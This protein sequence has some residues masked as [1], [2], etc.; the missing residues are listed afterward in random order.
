MRR[1]RGEDRR[2][3]LRAESSSP[4]ARG[5]RGASTPAR[6]AAVAAVLVA[7]VVVVVLLFGGN[8]GY[9]YTLMFQTGGQIVPGN[10]VLVAGQRVGMVDSIDLTDDNEAA[11]A[12]EHAGAAPRGHHGADPHDLALGRRQPLHLARPR[13]PTT[14]PRSSPVRRSRARTPP[15]R[16]TSTSSSTSSGPSSAQPCRSSSRATRPSTR[17]RA[18]SPTAPTSSSTPPSA[19]RPSS[20]PSSRSDSAALSRFLV[21]GSQTFGALADR[22]QDLSSLIVT[23]NHDPGRD[24]KPQRGPR[25]LARRLPRDAAPA[26]HDAGEPAKPPSTT[27]IPLVQASYPATKNLAPVPAQARARLEREHPGLL[28][29]RRHHEAAGRQQR[30]RRHA[31]R[32]AEDEE[33]GQEGASRRLPGP[34]RLGA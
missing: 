15:R 19:P 1:K 20:S 16:S 25:P 32:A 24:R 7:F 6:I 30:P 12:R 23:A 18:S 22:Q 34:R 17:A 33:E 14:P 2:A 26:Q 29:A 4:N 3:A 28:E 10:E 21:S 9:K 8:D 11:I 13:A 5:E 31:Q 27:S